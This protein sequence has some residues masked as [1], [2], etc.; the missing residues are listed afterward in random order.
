MSFDSQDESRLPAARS[1]EQAR[2]LAAQVPAGPELR[3]LGHRAGATCDQVAQ[4][5]AAITLHDCKYLLSEAPM[6]GTDLLRRA[7]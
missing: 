5:G 7:R 3:G 1:G 2:A 4:P 6:Q